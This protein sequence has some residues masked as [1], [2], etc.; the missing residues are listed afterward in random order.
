MRIPLFGFPSRFAEYQCT[1]PAG[2]SRS[3]RVRGDIGE[4]MNTHREDG[5]TPATRSGACVLA[6]VGTRACAVPVELVSET[7]RPLP[8]ERLARMP[9]FVLGMSVVR[10][11]PVPV[12]DAA[13]MLGATDA[14]PPRRFVSMRIGGRGAILAVGA[15]L[16]VRY[17]ARD[18]LEDLP[19]LM[20]D[21][22]ADV[23]E[24]IGT[25][26][27]ALLLVLRSGR[28]VPPGVWDAMPAEDAT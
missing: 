13:A 2:G 7:M 14:A 20:G 24:A 1:M 8:V 25:L 10:G 22:S 28:I 19:P 11:S 16:G 4:A 9:S 18:S 3:C 23:V 21:A 17:L 6:R 5:G 27:S 26:D 12:I 15:V